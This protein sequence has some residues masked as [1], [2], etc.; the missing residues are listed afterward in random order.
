[1]HTI[2][3]NENEWLALRKK[4]I[5]AS[6]FAVLLGLNPYSSPN[7]LKAEK[8]E[9]TFSGNS[10]TRVGQVLEPV[11]VEITNE[12]LGSNFKLYET[13][14]GKAFYTKGYMGAT[15]DATDGATLLE[16]K[17]TRPH[18][19]DKYKEIAPLTY[20]I[21]LQVQLYCTEIS[22]GYLSILSTDLT[23]AT[24]KLIWP[25]V[26][27]KVERNDAL[28]AL[29]EEEAKRFIEEPTYR[30][31]SKNKKKAQLLL[32]MSHSQIYVPKQL[33]I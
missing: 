11:V 10:F 15:P 20:L 12:V 9:S 4:V 33:D 21:Q 31:I 7:K 19:F 14:G 18:T 13:D 17:T 3:K 2:A 1:M 23:M 24:E 27:Y 29:M 16:C 28:C 8:V 25:V 22:E 26:I 32:S 30:V 5:T 6:E